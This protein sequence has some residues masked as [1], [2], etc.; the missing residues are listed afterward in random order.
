MDL[1]TKEQYEDTV[2]F[3]LQDTYRNYPW[4][5]EVNRAT[6]QLE[7]LNHAISDTMGMS[8]NLW[9]RR[10][11]SELRDLI[12]DMGGELL[13]RANLPRGS[14]TEEKLC[15]YLVDLERKLHLSISG[16]D[17]HGKIK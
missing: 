3:L 1:R 4:S 5:V 2:G 10:T 12:I 6:G 11:A 7:I 17:E 13:E 9:T 8:I 15:M 16:L 14:W